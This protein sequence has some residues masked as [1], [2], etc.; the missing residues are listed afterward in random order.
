MNGVPHFVPH[1]AMSEQLCTGNLTRA[2]GNLSYEQRFARGHRGGVPAPGLRVIGAS[3][4]FGAPVF[5]GDSADDRATARE[6]PGG[7]G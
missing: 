4:R 6:C 7:A 1:G 2:T 3:T 5:E